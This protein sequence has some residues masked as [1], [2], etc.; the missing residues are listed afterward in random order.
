MSSS[1]IAKLGKILSIWNMVL[2]FSIAMSAIATYF[3]IRYGDKLQAAKDSESEVF[4]TDA[5]RDIA[6][7]NERAQEA[8]KGQKQ[9]EADAEQAR[10][11]QREA[12]QQTIE[13][14]L[15]VEQEKV[16]RL[17]LEALVADRK[18][19]DDQKQILRNRLTGLKNPNVIISC[20]AGSGETAHFT[21][22]L[23]D[24]FRGA[25]LAVSGTDM[26][27]FGN[28]FKGITMNVGKNRVT[29][30]EIVATA[31]KAAGIVSDRITATLLP[32]KDTTMN[33][34]ELIVW[35]K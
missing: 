28:A 21:T 30:A 22:E 23:R 19:S 20:I 35:P 15:R 17:K 11:K 10:L 33:T 25:G 9:L 32:E 24:A 7:A 14:Q 18:V 8:I 26:M 1:D 13:L 27:E 2:F 34:L 12:E 29:D 4:K 6:Q 31:L 3:V 5:Q 16:E